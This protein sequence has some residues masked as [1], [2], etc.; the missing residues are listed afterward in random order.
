MYR[1]NL[2]QNWLTYAVLT[3]LQNEELQRIPVQFES[4]LE[5]INGL[6]ADKE[7]LVQQLSAWLSLILWLGTK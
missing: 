2:K 4:I 3:L 7:K 6:N 1:D 5:V